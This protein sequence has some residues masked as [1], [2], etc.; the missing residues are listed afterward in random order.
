VA[1]EAIWLTMRAG[2]RGGWRGWLALALLLGVMSGVVLAAAAGARRTYTA[3]PRLLTW[4]HA[5][6]LRIAASNSSPSEVYYRALGRLPHVAAMSTGALLSVAIQGHYRAVAQTQVYASPDGRLGVSV[7]RVKVLAGRLFDPADPR[8]VMINQK[9]ADEEHLR[10]GG[11]LRLAGIPNDRSGNPDLQHA[12]PLTF[13]V[14][15]IVVFNSQ[16]VPAVTGDSPTA[17]LSP[18]FLRTAAAR[19]MSGSEYGAFVRLQPGASTTEFLAAASA[20]AARY[21]ATGGKITG[22]STADQVVATERAIRPHAV[23]LALFAALAGVA[24][25][26]IIGQLLGR[27]LVLDSGWFGALRALGMTRGQLAAVSVARAGAMT[28][29]GGCLAVTIAIAAS[30]LMPIGAAR[31][32]EPA[33]GIDVNLAILAVGFAVILLAPL[34]VVAPAA[35]AAAAVPKGAPGF[36]QPTVMPGS[37][38]LGTA[39]GLAGPV[40]GRI[41]LRMAFERSHGL[42]AVPVRSALAAITVAVAAVTAAEVFGSS[43][44]ALV[45]TPH[46]YGQNWSRELDLGF[47]AAS[48]RMLARVVSAQP[49]VTGYAAGNY[50][51]ATIQGRTVAAIGITPVRSQGYI[52]VLDGHLP[53]GPG[54]IALGAQTLRSLHR[55]VGQAVQVTASGYGVVSHT[56]RPMR[57][58]GEAVFAS[59]GRR[60]EFTGTDLGNGAV[61]APS[62]LSVPFPQTGCTATCYNFLLLRYRPDAS[63]GAAAAR[64]T[65]AVT[66]LGCPPGSCSV[67]TDQRPLD[68]QGYAG[69]RDTPRILGALLTLLAVAALAHVLVTAVRRRRRDLA[70]LKII[71]MRRAQLLTVVSWQAAALTAA[72]LILGI[73]L[74]ILAGRWSWTL[75]TESIGVDPSTQVPVLLMLAEIGAAL[76]LAIITATVPGYTAARVRPAAILRTE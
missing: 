61:V 50:G 65:A 62:L 63:P 1:V 6:D 55:Q 18:A 66:R 38:P 14:S 67:T 29:A 34:A 39:L 43:L 5:S 76:L 54:Q 15:A 12:F 23:A 2:F 37:S 11:I 51:Q 42:T 70:I 32:A 20:L 69:I 52:T 13:R 45:S 10:P 22:I 75:F 74:G 16:V 28:L 3:Y 7:D 47:G 19:R 33:P 71:G 25:L 46:R 27:Q 56:T 64:L 73:P 26:V 72:A 4:G 8:A 9:I 35:W 41:G 17:L 40:T 59:L 21:P 53:S 60:G 24:A 44:I 36:T 30:L 48:E 68:I 57:I 49:G 58:V 31:L